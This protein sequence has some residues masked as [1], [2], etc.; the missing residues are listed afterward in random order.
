MKNKKFE[1][2]R[3]GHDQ[4]V[5]ELDYLKTVKRKE[6]IAALQEA[7]A[8]GDLSENAEYDAAR[9]EQAQI[10]A[11]V[12]E[13]EYILKNAHIIEDD[14]STTGVSIGKVVVF[15]ELPDGEEQTFKIVG[16]EEADPLN[17]KISMNSPIAQ[18]LYGR[19]AG[20]VVKVKIP[21]GEI[22]VKIVDVRNK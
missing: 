6:N 11:R 1:L 5:E 10:E 9:E 3:E 16:S 2:T 8:Q 4:F 22:N 12:Q 7:R 21:A 17:E 14:D 18:S 13:L 15:Q 20:D 19:E